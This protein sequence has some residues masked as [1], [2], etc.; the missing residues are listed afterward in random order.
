MRVQVGTLDALMTLSDELAKADTFAQ[1]VATKLAVSVQDLAAENDSAAQLGVNDVGVESYLAN[2][3]WDTAKFNTAVPVKEIARDINK[4]VSEIEAEMKTK[5]TA[6]TKLK[7]TLNALD[8][9]AKCVVV[10]V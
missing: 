1:G 5:L 8:R 9:K 4:R 10:D 3:H 7:G 6:Y 2:F